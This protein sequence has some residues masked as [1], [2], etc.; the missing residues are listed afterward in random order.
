[1]TSERTAV[2]G[3]LVSVGLDPEILVQFQFNPEKLQDRRAVDYAKIS[4]P[5][6]L[7]PVRQYNQGGD[8]TLTF[9]VRV[10]GLFR[11]REQPRIAR[12][13]QGGI[14]GELNKYRA[15][16]YP[17]ISSWRS[18]R[19]S[20]QPLYEQTKVFASPPRCRF[21]FGHRVVDCIVA[22]VGITEL[23]FNSRLAPMRADVSVTLVEMPRYG[24]E[25][26][27]LG[28]F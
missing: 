20:F 14:N 24:N 9:T 19:G 23:L 4:A 17:R 21:G 11:E 27:D 7:M 2:R 22:D 6:L 1:M 18:T 8:R 12:D 16:L 15:F 28:G 25:P 26:Q 3:F 10:D 5:G 13:D